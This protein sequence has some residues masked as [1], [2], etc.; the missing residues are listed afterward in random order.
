MKKTH[1][2]AFIVE[3]L[4]M[5]VLLLFVIVMITKTFVSARAVSLSARHLTEAVCLAEDIAEVSRSAS[6]QDEEI[7]LF[8]QM[9]QTKSVKSSGNVIEIEMDFAP[10]NA[11]RDDYTVII[12]RNDDAS[13]DGD[14][15]T[16]EISVYFADDSEPVYTL[17]AGKYNA[18]GAGGGS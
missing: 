1:N 10:G 16:E 12:T 3:L 4:L 14:Y 13:P 11:G 15:V 2:T 7:S 8:E 5:F 6:D 18:A 17:K 9:D